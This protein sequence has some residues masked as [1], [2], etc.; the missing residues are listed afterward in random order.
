MLILLY[1]PSKNPMALF[2]SRAGVLDE[3]LT[4]FLEY[5]YVFGHKSS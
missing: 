1:P 3:K 2:E 4:I 5:Y